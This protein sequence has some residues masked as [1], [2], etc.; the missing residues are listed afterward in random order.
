MPAP[1]SPRRLEILDAAVVVLAGHGLKGLTHRGIDREAGLP[2]G[3]S[4]AYFRSR[5]ALQQA[6]AEHVSDRLVQDVADLSDTLAAGDHSVARAVR[7]TGA[8][9]RR[10]LSHPELVLARLE[11]TLA[12]TRDEEL[13]VAMAS[14]RAQLVEVVRRTLEAGGHPDD[15]TRAATVVAAL[16]GVLLAALQ[17]PARQRP[18]FLR[19]SL[20]LLLGS[21]V[22]PP[23]PA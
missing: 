23:R 3:S 10:W 2:E 1:P 13:A 9:F 22:D 4:S 16:D 21:L 15:A 7:E 12:A 6:V 11:L 5:A 18:A 19:S 8:L 17:R 14:W 20:E